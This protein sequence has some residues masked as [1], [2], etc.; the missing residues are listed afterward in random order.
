MSLRFRLSFHIPPDQPPSLCVRPAFPG[1]L[2]DTL[3]TI[4]ELEHEIRAMQA[5]LDVVLQDAR[6]RMDEW[7]QQEDARKADE[8]P[9]LF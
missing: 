3:E 4:S 7:Q 9:S 2:T 1:D 5:E 6:R 8:E